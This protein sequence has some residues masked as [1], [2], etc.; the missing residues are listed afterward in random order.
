MGKKQLTF[1]INSR[2]KSFAAQCN[3][4]ADEIG[5]EDTFIKS[6]F[7]ISGVGEGL[8]FYPSGIQKFTP[9]LVKQQQLSDLRSDQVFKYMFK[10]KN[11]AHQSIK[12]YK[13]GYNHPLNN[14]SR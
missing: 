4:I 7:G 2:L 9:S 12:N 11:Q 14:K 6:N 8:V 3:K 10:A 1:W 5:T 13:T